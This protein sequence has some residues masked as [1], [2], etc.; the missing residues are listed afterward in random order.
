MERR[1]G[2]QPRRFARKHVQRCLR[3]QRRR[4][5]GGI[6][7]CRLSRVRRPVEPKR[8]NKCRP[9][10]LNMG[11]DADR[12]RGP[13]LRG[14]SPRK[15]GPREARRVA[16]EFGLRPLDRYG[17]SYRASLD[18]AQGVGEPCHR[19]ACETEPYGPAT[20]RTGAARAVSAPESVWRAKTIL[21]QAVAGVAPTAALHPW[22][23]Q[24]RVIRVKWKLRQ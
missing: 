19:E 5:G 2:H 7:Q 1:V 14:V 3:H 4:P 17:L 16:P 23:I 13:R 24:L 9:R 12:L 20:S 15:S 8:P 22:P 10:T 21:W 18:V 11:H 6:Q